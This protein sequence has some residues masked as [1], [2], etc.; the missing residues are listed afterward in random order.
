MKFVDCKTKKDRVA[1]IR[2]MVAEDASWAIRGMLRIYANQ[3]ADEQSSEDT[4]HLNGIGFTGSDANLLSSFAK[5]VE[6]GR[7]LSDKQMF[8]VFKKMP[9]YAGQ[10]EREAAA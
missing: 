1:F 5:Q 7:N 6:R 8:Y 2:R 9:K 3:T 4:K 10:L